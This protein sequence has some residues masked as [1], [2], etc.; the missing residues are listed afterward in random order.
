MIK[1][2]NEGMMII[3]KGDTIFNELISLETKI[4]GKV[5]DTFGEEATLEALNMISDMVKE[6]L[7][8]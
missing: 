3:G 4:F 5:K 1:V 8:I 2:S 6:E 7:E